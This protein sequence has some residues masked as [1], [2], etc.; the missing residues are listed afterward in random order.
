LTEQPQGRVLTTATGLPAMEGEGG[1]GKG[2]ALPRI[3]SLLEE[4]TM[5]EAERL[6]AE[7]G[8]SQLTRPLWMPGKGNCPANQ[9]R[10][11]LTT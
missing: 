2:D 1:R 6:V 10:F 5:E 8:K 9:S 7:R 3:A 4:M 11:C